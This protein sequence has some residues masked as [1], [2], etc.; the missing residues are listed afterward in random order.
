MSALHKLALRIAFCQ[1]VD[2]AQSQQSKTKQ[3]QSVRTVGYELLCTLYTV[4]GSESPIQESENAEPTIR[5]SAAPTPPLSLPLRT[6]RD[7]TWSRRVSWWLMM[8]SRGND[9]GPCSSSL[10]Y[11]TRAAGGLP[12]ARTRAV[13]AVAWPECCRH[14]TTTYTCR[15]SAP[16][17]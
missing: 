5:S 7:M 8:A 1:P 4:V 11:S 2:G 6:K 16:I 13:P 14:A 3:T 17:R 10:L 9:G 15:T 12:E